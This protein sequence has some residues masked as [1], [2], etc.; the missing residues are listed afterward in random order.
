MST[1]PWKI[2]RLP[3][4]L[5]QPFPLHPRA[6]PLDGVEQFDPGDIQQVR[7]DV[8]CRPVGMIEDMDAVTPRQV[9]HLL[10]PREDELADLRNAEQERGLSAQVLGDVRHIHLPLADLERAL[11]DRVMIL[12]DV[13]ECGLDELLL[14]EQV[15]HGILHPAERAVE[16]ERFEL[17]RTDHPV[18]RCGRDLPAKP[19]VVQIVRTRPGVG[20]QFFDRGQVCEGMVR[21]FIVRSRSILYRR[22]TQSPDVGLRIAGEVLHGAFRVDMNDAVD[23]QFRVECFLVGAPELF[24]QPVGHLV[25]GPVVRRDPVRFF[26]GK[27][28]DPAFTGGHST[29]RCTMITR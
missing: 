8:E 4:C 18:T 5:D 19:L 25:G 23:V 26:T 11:V 16:E 21:E 2:T 6:A 27:D 24:E 14:D 1:A 29:I 13:L 28:G 7:D 20:V 10:L 9:G 15:H 12:E 22:P 17:T 3:K